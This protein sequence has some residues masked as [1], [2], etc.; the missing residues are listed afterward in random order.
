MPHSLRITNLFLFGGRYVEI[1][2]NTIINLRIEINTTKEMNENV[3]QPGIAIQFH[4]FRYLHSLDTKISLF[5]KL[6]CSTARSQLTNWCAI[7]LKCITP[8]LA[9]LSKIATNIAHPN[10]S[11]MGFTLAGFVRL[12]KPT[13]VATINLSWYSLNGCVDVC[14]DGWYI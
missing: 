6:I 11:E 7:F 10:I 13:L 9:F 4:I 12:S 3:V 1:N 14:L 2:R 8:N 5:I